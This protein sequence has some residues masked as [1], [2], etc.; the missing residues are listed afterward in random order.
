LLEGSAKRSFCRVVRPSEVLD[1]PGLK[2]ACGLRVQIT[3]YEVG[4]G[5]ILY[6]LDDGKAWIP[7]VVLLVACGLGPVALG[8]ALRAWDR[9]R[10]K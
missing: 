6:T 5:L 7:V 10:R 4:M 1:A 8:L 2:R 3:G 9:T